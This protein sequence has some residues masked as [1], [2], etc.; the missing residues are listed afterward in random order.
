MSAAAARQRNSSL[1]PQQPPARERGRA[2]TAGRCRRCRELLALAAA[3][4][5]P[6]LGVRGC[7]ASPG[8][9]QGPAPPPSCR[10][11]RAFPCTELSLDSP[12]R[13]ANKRDAAEVSLCR[14]RLPPQ[15]PA[16]AVATAPGLFFFFF[17]V[18]R[19]VALPLLPSPSPSP[20]G[21]PRVKPGARRAES[22]EP[23]GG[24]GRPGL[25]RRSPLYSP[26]SQPHGQQQQQ[27]PGPAAAAPAGCGAA[28][29][30][31]GREGALPS[32]SFLRRSWGIA[33]LP[34]PPS[35]HGTR[36]AEGGEGKGGRK[37]KKEKNPKQVG[38]HSSRTEQLTQ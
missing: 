21:I 17:E 6:Q 36:Q 16:G 10:E 34:I 13:S 11:G 23:A 4:P 18:S 30:I 12:T 9:S 35:P 24:C 5:P 31:H 2:G 19:R 25:V 8:P 14:C 1:L 15:P 28:P 20:T 32:T 22:R 38:T 29:H 37:K 33:T 26:A 3:A 27:Q 7:P